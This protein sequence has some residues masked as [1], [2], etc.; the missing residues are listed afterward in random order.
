MEQQN[1]REHNGVTFSV[2]EA[3]AW[4]LELDRRT[5]S[6][7]NGRNSI[8]ELASAIFNK[9]DK[10]NGK[11]LSTN[12]FSNEERELL[13]SFKKSLEEQIINDGGNY[14]GLEI[15]KGM[16]IFTNENQQAIINGITGGIKRFTIVNRSTNFLTRINSNADNLEPDALPIE[17]PSG[18]AQV[19]I[20]G[21][22]HFKLSESLNKY[23]M[24]NGLGIPYAP[25]HLGITEKQA[26]IVKPDGS[27]EV[28]E[29]D[30]VEIYKNAQA[31]PMTKADLN[32]EFGDK[33]EGFEVV[34]PLIN[35]IYKKRSDSTNSNWDK[36]L[37]ET[38]S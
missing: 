19:G 25:E 27:T 10:V 36:I 17:L 12:D 15:T 20:K 32:N 3:A 29:L 2:E 34:C 5:K 1:I 7:Q 21:F 8:D 30:E 23:E 31:T 16:V 4:L 6:S 35:S 38:I 14:D 18:M 37:T 13:L 33:S 24:V 11:A 9:V 28:M 26:I 22:A